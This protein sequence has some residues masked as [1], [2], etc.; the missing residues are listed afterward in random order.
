LNAQ[1]VAFRSL[2]GTILRG[3]LAPGRAGGGIVVLMH[4]VRANR[5][6]MLRRAL[7]LHEHG[8]GV[9]LFDFQAHGE[10]IG[11][12]ITFGHLEGLDAASAVAFTKARLPGEKIG[13]VGVSL[14]GAAALLAPKPLNVDAMVLESVFPDI[15]S[16]LSDRLRARLGRFVGPIVTP[17]IAPLFEWLMPPILGVRMDEL[18][19]IDHIGDVGTPLL[20]AS[21]TADA[22][23]TITEAQA[24]F[25]HA[26]EPKQFWPVEGAAHVDL[27]RYD[28]TAYW[29]HVLPFLDAHLQGR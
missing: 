1:A 16:A 6:A 24:L 13:V 4:G 8:F 3:W 17:L 14:G 18:R 19:P 28:A 7:V 22:Y 2:S 21:G 23:T 12:H 25:A 11:R 5:L 27:E 9:L 10:S 20:V 15:H 29:D 26:R